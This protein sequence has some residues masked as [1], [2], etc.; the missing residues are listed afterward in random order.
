MVPFTFL[1]FVY[2]FPHKIAN[3][4]RRCPYYHMATWATLRSLKELASSLHCGSL[5]PLRGSEV[6]RP[7]GLYGVDTGS[8]FK[9][10]GFRV[11]GLAFRVQGLG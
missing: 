8:P 1:L 10:L 3:P 6:C 9:G 11:Q 7:P 2:G 4:K 5:P